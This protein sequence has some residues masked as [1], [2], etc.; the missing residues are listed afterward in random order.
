MSQLPK[1]R[2]IP[3]LFVLGDSISI[4]YGPVLERLLAGRMTYDRKGY[5]VLG[6]VEISSPLVNGGDS[7]CVL[8]YMEAPPAALPGGGLLLLN[9]GLHDL[10]VAPGGQ[11][12]RSTGAHQVPLD[13]YERNLERILQL[14]K[15]AVRQVIWVS[16][17][18]VADDLH[19]QRQAEFWRYDADVVAYN[20]CAAAKMAAAGVPV[21][22][23]YGFSLSLGVLAGR[24][25]QLYADHVHF[26]EPVRWLQA[27]YI[28]GWLGG[29]LDD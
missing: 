20:A 8:E 19:N 11:G 29:C 7:R 2:T 16:T 26:T 13:E 24:L 4:G 27:A 14:A 3:T 15:A 5:P 21:I 12:Q 25:E 23:L 22:D 18:P 28:A 9:C 10:R 6:E 1:T 17:T